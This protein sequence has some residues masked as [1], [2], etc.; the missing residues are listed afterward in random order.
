M[1]QVRKANCTEAPLIS[2]LDITHVPRS[3]RLAGS[4]TLHFGGKEPFC[5][6]YRFIAEIIM[7]GTGNA[8]EALGRLDQAIKPLTERHGDNSGDRCRAH[9]LRKCLHETS[10]GYPDHAVISMTKDEL[11]NAPDFRYSGASSAMNVLPTG[12]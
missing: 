5:G 10:L 1:R 2:M 3:H 12:K 9:S 6:R 4:S 8:H 11:K 7:P